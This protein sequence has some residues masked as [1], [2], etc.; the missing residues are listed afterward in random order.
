MPWKTCTAT[1][2]L[3]RPCA[4][5]SSASSAALKRSSI[6]KLTGWRSSAARAR[7]HGR[8]RVLARDAVL[9][10]LE[11]H[12]PVGGEDPRSDQSTRSRWEATAEAKR[13]RRGIVP[14]KRRATSL[15]RAEG[16]VVH[17]RRR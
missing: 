3:S 10:L 6:G 11:A 8:D 16:V 1:N 12:E 14:G 13:F 9:H 17:Q 2:A 15:T 5:E 4:G 7:A